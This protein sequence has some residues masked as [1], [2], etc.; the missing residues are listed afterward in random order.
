[1][2]SIMSHAARISRWNLVSRS[3]PKLPSD[4]TDRLDASR[5]A[6]PGDAALFI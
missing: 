3:E 4:R 5:D 2:V 6:L 1:M